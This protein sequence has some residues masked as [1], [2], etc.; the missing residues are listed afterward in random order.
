MSEWKVLFDT[1]FW[2]SVREDDPAKFYNLLELHLPLLV[3]LH[4]LQLNLRFLYFELL[5]LLLLL[6]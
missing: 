1:N 6:M 4:L 5:H 3:L 2:G